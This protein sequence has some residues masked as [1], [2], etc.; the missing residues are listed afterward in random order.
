MS[1]IRDLRASARHCE[2]AR[3]LVEQTMRHREDGGLAMSAFLLATD[4]LLIKARQLE[5]DAEHL[6]ESVEAVPRLV[7]NILGNDVG[8]A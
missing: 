6:C 8:E 5:I 7:L 1:H 3:R 2:E 4:K